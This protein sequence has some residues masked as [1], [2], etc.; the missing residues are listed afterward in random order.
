MKASIR[1][2]MVFTLVA[3]LGIFVSCAEEPSAPQITE[4]GFGPTVQE[5][6]NAPSVRAF[7]RDYG[8]NMN[9]TLQ[10]EGAEYRLGAV[11]WILSEGAQDKAGIFVF[12]NDRGNKRLSS[13]WVPFDPRRGG[14][15]LITYIVDITEGSTASGLT[16]AQTTDAID[17]AMR[18]WNDVECSP[19]FIY[20]ELPQPGVDLGVIEFLN[21][22]GGNPGWFADITHAGWLPAGVLPSNVIGVTFTFI[23]TLDGVPTDI[24]NNGRID[25]AFREIYYNDIF[26]WQIGTAVDVETIALHE[27]GH[28]LSQGHF[29]SAFITEANNML[30]FNPR[31]LMN[32]AYS[33]VNTQVTETD[34]AG[35]CSTWGSWPNN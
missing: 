27:A 34:L 17:R 3:S 15:D 28:G 16:T 33:G 35:H 7:M 21:G 5:P 9:A 30:H 8:E 29:G 11:E 4:T 19:R 14:S 18:T 10:A 12:F 1:W 13:H 2:I 31:A 22:L 20:E 6:G 24:D 26:N 32:A 25:T 23:W